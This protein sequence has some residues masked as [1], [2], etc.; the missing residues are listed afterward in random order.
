[1]NWS[2]FLALSIKLCNWPTGR[3]PLNAVDLRKLP[4]LVQKYI[5]LIQ[6]VSYYFGHEFTH[7]TQGGLAMIL[8]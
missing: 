2:E 3:W 4:L 7:T 5:V 6:G 8:Q 1:M